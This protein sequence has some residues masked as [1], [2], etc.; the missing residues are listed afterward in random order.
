MPG[1]EWSNELSVKISTFDNEHKKLI[2]ML[3]RLHEAMSQG[4]G[5]KA[6]A[7][8]LNEL[9]GYTKTHFIH[10]EEA[11]KKYNYAGLNKHKEAHDEFISKL[12]DAQAQY[13]SDSLSLSIQM[14]NFLWSWIQNHIKKIDQSYSEFLIQHGMK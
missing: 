12:T 7:D 5:H 9:S 4:Q 8:I 14:F 10:E 1:I 11:M 3:N 13:N 6:L 2:D